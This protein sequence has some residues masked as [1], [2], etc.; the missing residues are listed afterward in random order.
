MTQSGP[1]YKTTLLYY[2]A[3]ISKQGRVL[4]SSCS[5]EVRMSSPQLRRAD[6][7]MPEDRARQLLERGFSGRLATIGEDGWPVDP[8]HPTYGNARK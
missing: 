2:S 8:Q 4:R 5:D 1:L 3:A 6:R 7:M